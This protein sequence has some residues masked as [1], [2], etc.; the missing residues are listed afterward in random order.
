MRFVAAN[1]TSIEYTTDG[2]GEVE[3]KLNKDAVYTVEFPEDP[4]YEKSTFVPADHKGKDVPVVLNPLPTDNN[5]ETV[6][7]NN[8]VAAEGLVAKDNFLIGTLG[9]KKGDKLAP[10]TKV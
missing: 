5:T 3:V 9:I 10:N 2:M 6:K 7:E 1:G 4:N 8:A